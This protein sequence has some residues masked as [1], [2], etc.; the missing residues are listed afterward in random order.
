MP[1]GGKA[2]HGLL[3]DA[4]ALG[5]DGAA[6][7]TG[8][9]RQGRGYGGGGFK[10]AAALRQAPAQGRQQQGE[11]VQRPLVG[12]DAAGGGQHGLLRLPAQSLELL[13]RGRRHAQGYK[14]AKIRLQ[15]LGAAVKQGAVHVVMGAGVAAVHQAGLG[16]QVHLVLQGLPGQGGQMP[17]GKVRQDIP[18]PCPDGRQTVGPA[19]G[20]YRHRP[21]ADQ[22][23]AALGPG[24]LLPLRGQ[25]VQV[26]QAAH[27]L[28]LLQQKAVLLHP[29]GRAV[30]DQQGLGAGGGL[31]ELPVQGLPQV[32]VQRRKARLKGQADQGGVLHGTGDVHGKGQQGPAVSGG[33]RP[34]AQ[35]PAVTGKEHLFQSDLDSMHRSSPAPGVGAPPGG[36]GA[37][38]DAPG[39][40]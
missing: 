16:G 18:G 2:G 12:V 9:R 25:H 5:P 3:P 32:P 33:Q 23:P 20:A 36:P 14:A 8:G 13:R 6:V 22:A 24:Q 1:G 34:L 30:I 38:A 11:A 31:D 10:G 27:R 15:D 39:W 40:R 29:G 4:A 17:G 7:G 35:D 26:I 19:A 28:P 37:A 21:A